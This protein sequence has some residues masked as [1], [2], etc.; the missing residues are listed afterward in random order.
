MTTEELKVVVSADIGS[1]QSNM[2]K[3]KGSVES[4]AS[5]IK[6]MDSD[7]DF[8]G[9][10]K[11]AETLTNTIKRQTKELDTLKEKLTNAY[12]SGKNTEEMAEEVQRLSSELAENKQKL[13]EAKK[14]ADAFDAT[15]EKIDDTLDEASNSTEKVSTAWE[16]FK[17]SFAGNL[18][19]NAVSSITSELKS[20]ASEAL[21]DADALN[22]FEKTMDFAGFDAKTIKQSKKELKDYADKTVFNLEDVMNTS[23]QLA[24]NGIDNFEDLTEAL[25]NV[26]AVAGGGADEFSSVA[27]AMTQTAGA[28]KL[29][30]E[31]WNQIA[32]AI[33][34]A[35]GIIQD[36]LKKNGA[37]TGEFREAM[38]NGEITAEEFNEAITGIGF[39]DAAVEAASATDTFEGAMGNLKATVEDVF[40]DIIDA[41][42][43]EN[44]TGA[45]NKVGDAVEWL[46]NNLDVIAPVIGIVAG[47]FIAYKAAMG[48]SSLIQ[49]VAEAQGILNMVMAMNPIGLVVVAIAALAAG[50]VIAYKKSATFR[51]IVNTAFN[52]AKNAIAAAVGFIK[53]KFETLKGAIETVKTKFTNLKDNVIGK[54]TAMKDKVKSIIDT[55]KGFFHFNVS[56][57]HIPTP[58]FSIS[59]SGWKVGDLLKGEIPKLSVSWYAKGGVV[60]GAT[61]IGAGEKGAEAI[62]PLERNTGWMD[63]LAQK[64]GEYISLDNTGSGDGSIDITLNVGGERFGEVVIDSINEAQAAAGTI[65]LNI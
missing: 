55:I 1:F 9:A 40:L 26:V 35:S 54:I 63:I 51:K 17:G 27:M 18:I 62:V 23:A 43:M 32:N 44:I 16:T 61:L 41:I 38:A 53:G 52:G 30:T 37:Y 57:P 24:A 19:A 65:L 50:L 45:I 33:P 60:D 21:N 11:G 12:A 15:M 39:S 34:G 28:G 59:P 6:Q 22:K 4:A 10:T 49:A 13:T 14:A 47:A 5:S 31:N 64:I 42:G 8:E 7:N 3:V 58:H 36:A 20:L 48:I 56:A 25:G 29:T 2:D 46:K